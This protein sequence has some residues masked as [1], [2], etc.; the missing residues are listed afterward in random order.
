L[1]SKE[2]SS[3]YT[4]LKSPS[5]SNDFNSLTNNE[6]QTLQKPLFW[7]KIFFWSISPH[8]L[9]KLCQWSVISCQ[10]IK[11]KTIN[12]L[13]SFQ[14][15]HVILY[16]ELS[17]NRRIFLDGEMKEQLSFEEFLKRKLIRAKNVP[18][19]NFLS[20]EFKWRLASSYAVLNNKS[21][22]HKFQPDFCQF[23]KLRLGEFFITKFL[24]KKT[25][26]ESFSPKIPPENFLLRSFYKSCSE[27]LLTEKFHKWKF[28]SG[29][30]QRN[31]A[32]V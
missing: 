25:S 26:L 5:Q 19:K 11:R 14:Y 31:I 16:E 17:E 4:S 12:G 7:N 2:G 20:K 24:V 9:S 18:L 15:L 30:R 27:N 1:H 29:I 3:F 10:N 8:I 6:L 13:N 21:P 23:R 22:K 28:S 32:T